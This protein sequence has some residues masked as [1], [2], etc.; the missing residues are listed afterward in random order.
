[1]AMG[2]NYRVLEKNKP[3]QPHSV[4]LEHRARPETLLFESH[5]IAN[6]CKK[7]YRF[8]L[9]LSMKMFS[10]ICAYSCSRNGGGQEAIC[11]DSRRVRMSRRLAVERWRIDDLIFSYGDGL[12]LCRK[13]SWQWNIPDNANSAGFVATST[14]EW[15]QDFWSSKGSQ[16]GNVLLLV[17]LQRKSIAKLN[18]ILRHHLECTASP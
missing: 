18:A 14:A 13:N 6:L 12:F 2:K 5:T 17:E 8:F 3:E 7:N 1:M 4:I 15:G 11:E 16:F 9:P 10:I